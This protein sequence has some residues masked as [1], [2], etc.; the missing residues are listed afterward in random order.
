MALIFE[1]SEK[2]IID[3]GEMSLMNGKPEAWAIVA[4]NAVFPD[5]AGP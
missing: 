1:A 2:P 5:P 3:S 4:A